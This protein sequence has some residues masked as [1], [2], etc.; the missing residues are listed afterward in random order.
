MLNW[1][2]SFGAQVKELRANVPAKIVE[3]DEMHTYIGSKTSIPGYGLLLIKMQKDFS[4]VHWVLGELSR[5][6]ESGAPSKTLQ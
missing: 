5:G 1:I 6:K 3:L 4:T 2:R